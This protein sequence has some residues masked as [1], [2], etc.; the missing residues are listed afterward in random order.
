MSMEAPVTIDGQD[1]R[2]HLT[3]HSLPDFET[4]S[5]PSHSRLSWFS[6][7]S[8][9]LVWTGLEASARKYCNSLSINLPRCVSLDGQILQRHSRYKGAW[10]IT[11]QGGQLH[12]WLE[13][14]TERNWRILTIPAVV[15]VALS[16]GKEMTW[17]NMTIQLP[18][19]S[20]VRGEGQIEI[21]MR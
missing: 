16:F 21:G 17:L 18:R 20:H 8:V 6:K 19:P 12:V 13:R 3:S 14:I 2:A 10:R 1:W 11:A 15:C 4:P 9:K 5:Q 7:D